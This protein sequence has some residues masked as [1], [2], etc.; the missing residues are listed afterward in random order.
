MGIKIPTHKLDMSMEAWKV[1][2]SDMKLETL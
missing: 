2:I 1:K